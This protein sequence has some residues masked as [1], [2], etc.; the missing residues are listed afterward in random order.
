MSHKTS[1]PDSRFFLGLDFGTSACKAVVI[2]ASKAIIADTEYVYAEPIRQGSSRYQDPQL[3]SQALVNIAAKLA[4]FI[5]VKRIESIAIAGTAATILAI[6]QVGEPV[7]NAL[8]YD[9]RSSKQQKLLIARYADDDNL[10]NDAGSSLAKI[11][12]LRQDYPQADY[13]LHQTDWLT[14]LLCGRFDFSDINNSLKSGYDV[15]KRQ[16]PDWVNQLSLDAPASKSPLVPP[17]VIPGEALGNLCHQIL[18]DLGFSAN[19]TIVAGTTDSTA[20]TLATGADRVGDAITS[21]GSTLVLKVI[22]HQPVFNTNLGIYSHRFKQHWLTGG[23]SN[24]GGA[25][26][27]HFFSMAEIES[28]SAKISPD[29]ASGLNYYPLIVKGER[30]PL[31]N[32]EK[33][34]NLS[35]RPKDDALFLQA[36]LEGISQIEIDGYQR[37]QSVGA[38]PIKRLFSMGGGSKNLVW[39]QI[40]E[41]KLLEL[42]PQISFES[43]LNSQAAFGCA[44]IAKG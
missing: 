2:D 8:M 5:P 40:R 10:A 17:V 16:W 22:A 34:P 13:V 30:F 9:D 20:A 28:L 37:L 24:S 11:L 38:P 7:S 3:W 14:G 19:T 12:R 35:P 26:L 36:I 44:L 32:P 6:N 15:I 41:S 33:S 43:P 23:A 1:K 31:N 25:V 4:D 27:K 39:T 18:L 21:L 29:Q 42:N